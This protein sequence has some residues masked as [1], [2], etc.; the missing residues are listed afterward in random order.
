M[1]RAVTGQLHEAFCLYGDRER[2]NPY[3]KHHSTVKEACELAERLH[4]PSLILW[5]TEDKNIS[6]RK[7]LYTSEGK[8]FYHG[9]LFVPD[10][11]EIIEL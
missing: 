2:F 5:H 11:G 9:R 10:D 7:K 6:G 8:E 1:P 3:E 4:I